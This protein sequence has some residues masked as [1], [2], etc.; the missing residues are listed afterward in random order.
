MITYIMNL[1][2]RIYHKRTDGMSYEACNT[3]QLV[4]RANFTTVEAIKSRYD[5][6]RPCV[7]CFPEAYNPTANA[8]AT[9]P[10]YMGTYSR[11]GLA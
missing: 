10:P 7:R 9:S 2:S 3:D 6:A 1:R 5:N 11:G 8:A 4:H